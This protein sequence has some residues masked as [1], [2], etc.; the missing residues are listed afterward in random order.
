MR[1][2]HGPHLLDMNQIVHARFTPRRL[3]LWVVLAV[4]AVVIGGALIGLTFAGGSEAAKPATYS[5]LN[6]AA[7]PM[8]FGTLNSTLK[9]YGTNPLTDAR[10]ALTKGD[11]SL[12]VIAP[13][14]NALCLM[15]TEGDVS[16]ST[17]SKRSVL[18]ADDVIYITHPTDSEMMD[19]YGLVADGVTT[20]EA[21]GV[22]SNVANNVFLIQQ[23]RLADSVSI[24]GSSVGRTINIR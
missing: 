19:I 23:A 15:V 4:I 1:S 9:Q 16:A 8:P 11:V 22:R 13:P 3:Y 10:L 18:K 7:S 24:T 5:I 6:R 20:A 12:F 14:E 17:C 2:T 21:G